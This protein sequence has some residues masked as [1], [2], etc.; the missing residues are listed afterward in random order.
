MSA[1]AQDKS[2]LGSSSIKMRFSGVPMERVSETDTVYESG[3]SISPIFDLRSEKGWGV[4]YSPSVLVSGSQSGIYMHTISAGYERWGKKSFDIAFNYSHYFFTHNTNI[5]YSA[6]N[7]EVY[8]FLDYSKTWIKPVIAT[9]VGFGWDSSATAVHDVG[10]AAG[11]SHNFDWKNKG[12]FSEIEMTPSAFVNVGTNGYFS[13]L[14]VSKYI[15]NSHHFDSYVKHKGKGNDTTPSLEFSNLELNL[16]TNFE[17]GS[18]SL[19]PTGSVFF[20][21]AAGDKTIS[22]YGEFTLQYSF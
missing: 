17:R 18:F 7:N 15:S 21:M 12:M 9:S 4:T 11:V 3:L 8:F 1:I 6:I 19:H 13:F 5:P 14:Q 10:I 22:A 20:P 16:E 2:P